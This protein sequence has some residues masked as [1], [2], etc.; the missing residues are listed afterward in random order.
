MRTNHIPLITGEQISIRPLPDKYIEVVEPEIHHH[1]IKLALAVDGPQQIALNQFIRNHLLRIVQR[2]QSLALPRIHAFH[3]VVSPVA[4]QR[5]RKPPLLFRRH[6]QN[7]FEPLIGRQVEHLFSLD[8]GIEPVLAP[9]RP[10][11]IA[12]LV[13]CR[14]RFRAAGLLFPLFLLLVTLQLCAIH[15]A[16]SCIRWHRL[17]AFRHR[18]DHLLRR[19]VLHD[20]ARIH[21]QRAERRQP[22]LDRVII[23]LLRMK[24]LVDPLLQPHGKHALHIPRPRPKRQPIQRMQRAFRFLHLGRG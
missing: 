4:F 8:V 10:L 24:L 13:T 5:V 16:L 12:E 3:E 15:G 23:N 19:K 11:L 22:R 7:L 18:L 6:L 2:H 14:R 21:P 20:L 1:F 9:P 17:L